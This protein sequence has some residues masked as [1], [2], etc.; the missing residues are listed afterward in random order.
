[1][2]VV[3]IAASLLVSSWSMLCRGSSSA[4][5]VL[6]RPEKA[7]LWPIPCQ[8]H[9]VHVAGCSRYDRFSLTLEAYVVQEGHV[10]APVMFSVKIDYSWISLAKLFSCTSH[11]LIPVHARYRRPLL[12]FPV[13]YAGSGLPDHFH[14]YTVAAIKPLRFQNKVLHVWKQREKTFRKTFKN[15]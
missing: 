7:V 3:L 2:T 8:T 15:K 6:P 9:P 13:L 11:L 4:A 1:M 12:R 5:F 10:K 14:C